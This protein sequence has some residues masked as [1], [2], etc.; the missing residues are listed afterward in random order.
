MLVCDAGLAQP[1]VDP[2]VFM[3]FRYESGTV[4]EE[5]VPE[6]RLA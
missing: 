5:P 3:R 1:S 2:F 6:V 4:H